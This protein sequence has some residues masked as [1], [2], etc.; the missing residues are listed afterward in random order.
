MMRQKYI[1]G[2][3]L[4]EWSSRE[5]KRVV[6]RERER[7]R[8]KWGDQM[9]WWLKEGTRTRKEGKKVMYQ[10]IDFDQVILFFA[11]FSSFS[12]FLTLSLPDSFLFSLPYCLDRVNRTLDPNMMLMTSENTVDF[13]KRRNL[14]RIGI[15]S[16]WMWDLGMKWTGKETV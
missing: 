16:E 14:E 2:F 3:G 10:L 9:G 13:A 6:E 8:E 5:I 11:T 4:E 7:K 12:L 1:L 15:V